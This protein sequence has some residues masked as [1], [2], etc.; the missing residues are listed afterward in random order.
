MYEKAM[1]E[2]APLLSDAP[3]ESAAEPKKDPEMDKKVD[4]L[5]DKVAETKVA[6]TANTSKES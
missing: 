6:E 4:E 3:E 2:N 5:A 1:K